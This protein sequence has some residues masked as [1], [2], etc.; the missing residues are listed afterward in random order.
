ME[1]NEIKSAF[2]G[3]NKAWDEFKTTN[4]DRIKAEAKGIFDGLIEEKLVKLND[5]ISAQEKKMAVLDEALALRPKASAAEIKEEAREL[6]IKGTL[7][8]IRGGVDGLDRHAD[9]EIKA[10]RTN[11]GAD[12]GFTIPELID[13]AMESK[14]VDVSPIRMLAQV[15]QTSTPNWSKLV[16]LKGTVSGWVSESAARAETTSPQF[17]SIMPPIGTLYAAPQA[18][19]NM[20]DDATF[21]V[22]SWLAGEIGEEFARAEGAAFV[23]GSGVNQPLGMTSGTP[24]S[25]ADATRTFGTVQYIASGQAAAMPTAGTTLMDMVAAIKAGYRPNAAWLS[26][27]KALLAV[28]KYNGT[29][30]ISFWEPSMQAGTP[31]RLLGYPVYEAEDF[32]DSATANAF[33]MAFGDFRRGYLITDRVGVT[34][35]RDNLTNKPFVIFYATKRLGGTVQNSEAIKLLKL[36]T[37]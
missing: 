2:E 33:P 20:L 34:L 10:L 7:A 1:Q 36:A 27:K 4:A 28:R 35:I 23:S 15:V 11:V 22:E 3:L 32:G 19:Q 26:T 8:F 6:A 14:L 13:S 9:A 12:G 30:S 5:E 29:D 31:S 17:A 24:V 16:S 25:T 21:D 18:T 37:S